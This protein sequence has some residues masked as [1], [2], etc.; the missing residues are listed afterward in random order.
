MKR[1]VVTGV[2]AV[3]P[4]GNNVETAW[5]SLINGK[6]GIGIVTRYDPSL[7]KAKVVAEVK[8]FDPTQYIE[9]R[10]CRKLDLYCQ[11][12]IAAATQAVEDS[13]IKDK[14]EPERFGCYVGSGV[15][16]IITFYDQCE[17]MFTDKN[18]SPF[19]IPMMISNIAAG[20]IAIKFNAKGPCLPVVT[21][22]STS[23]HAIGEAFHAIKYGL[24][25]AVIAGGTEA[26]IHP[27]TIKGFT[28][29]K[30]LTMSD[31]PE[32]ASIPFDKR[33]NG[34]VLGEGA[35]AVILEEYE[36]AVARGANIY[37]EI[38]G[39]GNTCDAHH[40]TAPDPE[41]QGAARCI[42]LALDEA[43]YKGTEEIYINAHGTSTPMNDSTETKA[44][45]IALGEQAYKAHISSTKSMTGHMLGA[46]GAVEAIAAVM[47]LKTGTIPPT[48]GYKEPDPECDL[49]IV[50]NVGR[51]A[52]IKYALSNALGFGGHNASVVF[53]KYE[54]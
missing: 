42:K 23:T 5:E 54:D 34:F 31:D 1:V 30:A 41:A 16:G 38:C 51:E 20:N 36:H 11:Y 27:L 52:D 49:D 50:P 46:T 40:V 47:A 19:F 33:R 12:A 39:Y 3:T 48:M 17:N 22:C 18:I 25:D 10:E 14:I 53:K 32:N 35:G 8:G 29:C 26:A 15:G 6:S 44:F 21:A 28:S 24:A 2:G 7:T 45:K 9:K 13:G 37:A 43:G 4:V